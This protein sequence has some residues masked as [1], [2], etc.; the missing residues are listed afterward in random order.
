LTA[1]WPH[2]ADRG[3]GALVPDNPSARLILIALAVV[4]AF[5][6]GYAWRPPSRE[7]ERLRQ[8]ARAAAAQQRLLESQVAR[9]HASLMTAQN[10]LESLGLQVEAVELQLDGVDYLSRQVRQ[11]LGLPQADVTWQGTEG[12]QGGRPAPSEVPSAERLDLVRRRL[13]A[14]LAELSGLREEARNRGAAQ[15]PA[16]G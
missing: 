16:D 10:D 5:A 8:E 12:G 13:A 14:G 15:S 3:L 6:L 7:V 4:G 1:N 2:E 9:Q 11:E